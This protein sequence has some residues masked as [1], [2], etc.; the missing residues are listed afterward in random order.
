MSTTGSAAGVRAA[1]KFEP[2]DRLSITPR[3][4]YQKLE[5]DGWNRID[6]FNIL[7][8]PYTTTRPAVTL[9]ERQQFTQLE[10]KYTDDFFLGDFN[11]TY[12]FGDLALTSVT[13][14]MY[15]DVLVV[16]DATALTASITGGTIGLAENVYT[17]DAPLDDATKAK[18][19]TQELR[20]SGTRNRLHWVAGGFYS[21]WIGTTD[22]IC[23][24]PVSR[25]SRAFRP[26]GSGRPRTSCSSRTSATSWIS[27][28]YSAKGPSRSRRSSV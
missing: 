1:M 5:M 8:N 9:G 19:W 23:W 26:R 14:Y 4:A 25:I 10:E 13:S 7:A 12:R 20:L 22:R 15:R 3:I 16:R 17:L 6:T 11:L 28:R 18:V 21:S 27:S 2:N 24:S